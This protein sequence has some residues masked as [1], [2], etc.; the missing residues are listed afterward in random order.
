MA[1]VIPRRTAGYLLLSALIL[2]LA[3]RFYALPARPDE[4]LL[5]TGWLAGQMPGWDP[6]SELGRPLLT[7][8]RAGPW[9]PLNALILLVPLGL[10]DVLRL[11]AAFSLAGIGTWLWHVARFGARVALADAFAAQ[12][13]GLC[14]VSV[15]SPSALDAFLWAPWMLWAIE[16]RRG[17]ELCVASALSILG[18]VPLC[19]LLALGL[20]LLSLLL[21]HRHMLGWLALGVCLAALAWVP[22]LESRSWTPHAGTRAPPQL[23]GDPQARILQNREAPDRLDASVASE[24]GGLLV[25][26]EAWHPGWKATVAGED[27]PVECVDGLYRGV[28]L[29]AGTLIVRTKFE[30]FSLRL[31]A[32]TSFCALT[33]LVL[34]AR[35]RRVA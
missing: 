20:A 23:V 28:R 25:F 35:P 22:L 10:A 13:A 26:H 7:A 16:R 6:S 9:Y 5:R 27:A 3:T 21:A 4:A 17:R 12:I 30:P 29:P 34:L 31:G 32:W 14:L 2:C 33:L 15:A 19:S 8:T 1:L 18:G 24:H 11:F